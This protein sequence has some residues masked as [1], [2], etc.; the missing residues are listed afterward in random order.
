[1]RDVVIAGIGSTAFGR[2]AGTP[3][4][5]LAVRAAAEAYGL[6]PEVALK[7]LGRRN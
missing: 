7:H 4:E 1:M 5:Q 3:I 2:H 6:V